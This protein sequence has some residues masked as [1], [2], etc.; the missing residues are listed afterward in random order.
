MENY[1]E[2]EGKIIDF[3]N[4]F[5]GNIRG[6]IVGCDPDIGITIV[7]A[8]NNDRYLFC[9]TGP[10]SPNWDFGDIEKERYK[11]YFENAIEQFKK[12]ELKE[13]IIL[14]L[15]NFL[16]KKVV[17]DYGASADFCPFGQ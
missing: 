14:N 1:E 3:Y 10:F 11:Q 12:G 16:H 9:L 8:D 7:D 15:R 4:E 6:L 17:V 2:F 13:E 5:L